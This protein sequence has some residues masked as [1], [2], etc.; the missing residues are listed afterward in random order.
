MAASVL[1]LIRHRLHWGAQLLMLCAL[2]AVFSR[3]ILPVGYM[4]SV[5]GDRISVTLCGSGA[6]ATLDLGD[7]DGRGGD[8]KAAQMDGVCV[9]AVAATAAPPPVALAAIAA[10]VAAPVDATPVL[11][12][13]V[14]IGQGLAAPPPPSHAPPVQV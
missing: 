13:A 6:S 11:S 1:R 12:P 8:G 5:S 14:A 3:A 2:A 7:H 4:A 9:F 10:P